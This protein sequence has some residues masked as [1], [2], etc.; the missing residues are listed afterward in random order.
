MMLSDSKK[1]IKSNCLYCHTKVLD[2]EK[3]Y[4]DKDLKLRLPTDKICYGCHLHSPHLNAVSHSVKPDK[5][6]II[7]IKKYEKKANRVFPLSSDGKIICITCHSSHQ[8]DVISQSLAAGKQV[9]NT[10]LD[11]GVAYSENSWNSIFKK[12]KKKRI[13]SIENKFKTKIE[14]NYRKIESEILLR[15][16]AKNAELCMVCHRF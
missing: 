6:M 5:K 8:V 13:E 2:V 1:I 12:D 11:K 14:L 7:R 4:E 16:A 3:K 9:I 10:D 15:L